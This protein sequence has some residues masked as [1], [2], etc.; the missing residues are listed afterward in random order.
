MHS[1]MPEGSPYTA[2]R[3]ML[4]QVIGQPFSAAGFRLQDNVMHHLRG[5]FRYEKALAEGLWISVAFQMLPY[6]D[7]LGRFQVA[8]RRSTADAVLQEISLARLLWEG[9]QVGQL[10][11]PE[12][13]WQFRTPHE[14]A[15]ALVEA[16]KL[17]FAF[18]VPY[19]EGSLAPDSH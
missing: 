12:H 5:L 10:G 6:A 2:F 11:S 19:L 18:G 17:I 8:L 1:T 4:E 9:F 14:L 16:G 3:T 15:H 13:W 7:G